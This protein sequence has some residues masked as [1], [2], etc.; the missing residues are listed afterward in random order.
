MKTYYKVEGGCV[1]CLMCMDECPVG[2]IHIEENV[3]S[4][5]DKDKCIGCGRCARNCQAEAIIPVRTEE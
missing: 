1:L 2:A 4:F 5:I 3:S